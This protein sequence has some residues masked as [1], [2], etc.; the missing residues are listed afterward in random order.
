MTTHPLP[1]SR[2][3]LA[4]QQQGTLGCST[5]P[6]ASSPQTRVERDPPGS[7]S[8]L[9]RLKLLE[10]CRERFGDGAPLPP[11]E[12]GLAPVL[13]SVVHLGFPQ[14]LPMQM[15]RITNKPS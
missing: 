5:L 9:C 15:H 3:D 12:R 11:L 1:P 4:K 6:V 13:L 8:C 10:L 2:P 7:L 14:I